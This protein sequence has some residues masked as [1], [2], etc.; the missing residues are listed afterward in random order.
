MK[1]QVG[2]PVTGNQLVGRESEISAIEKFI[3]MGQSVALIAP[4][5]FGKTSLL[6]EI[7]QRAKHKDVFTVYIDLFS[8][9]DIY[10][11]AADITR[12]VLLN[13][14]L[15]FT[16]HQLKNN[17]TDL[18]RN[19]RFKQEVEGFEYILGFG[20]SSVNEWEMLRS[21]L[22]LLE[23]Y[24]ARY[25]KEL[26]CVFDEFGDL[27]KLDGSEII[28]LFRSELQTQQKTTFLF[29]GSYESVMSNI[30]VSPSSPFYRFTRILH[31]DNVDPGDFIAYLIPLFRNEK[32]YHPTELVEQIAGFT[33]GH[34]YYTPLMAQQAI[35]NADI[36]HNEDY[37]F[38][39]LIEF[40]VDAETNYLEKVWDEISAH[41][42][43]KTVLLAL[44]Q[45]DT[46]PYVS[47]DTKKINV[48]RTLKRLTTRG[49]LRKQAG[50]YHLTDPLLRHW[51]RDKILKL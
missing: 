37:S 24:A 30:F 13:R 29:S 27:E 44:V 31:L 1:L 5:R 19:V 32:L 34:P 12:S 47:I 46:S 21:S 18:M 10:S 7:L 39:Q 28:K 41:Q 43:E 33:K 2:K 48:S 25:Q 26:I 8:T 20:Q 50:G 9:P 35:F 15:D 6:L 17:I 4:R 51:I 49:L 23:K 38:S 40:S 14:K 11:L 22:R 45:D 3:A 42:Q 36:F 16:L